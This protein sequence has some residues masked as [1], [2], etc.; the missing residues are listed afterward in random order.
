MYIL[1]PVRREHHDARVVA[2]SIITEQ[3]AL[4]TGE[5]TQNIS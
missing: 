3:T 2:G 5:S 4:K 1:K